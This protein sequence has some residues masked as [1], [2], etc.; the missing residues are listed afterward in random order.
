[1]KA[2][3]YNPLHDW[4]YVRPN[5]DPGVESCILGTDYFTSE[6]DVI[7]FVK[8]L[9]E[10]DSVGTTCAVKSRRSMGMLEAFEAVAK[11][12]ESSD[13]KAKSYTDRQDDEDSDKPDKAD[14]EPPSAMKKL[15]MLVGWN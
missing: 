8:S 2:G 12:E 1:M 15:K 4:Y 3:K 6:I 11:D 5:R 14:A 13:S 7:E 9:D 10:K